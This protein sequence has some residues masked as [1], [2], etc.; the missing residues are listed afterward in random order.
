MP[1]DSWTLRDN[2][3]AVKTNYTERI[4]QEDSCDEWLN[5]ELKQKELGKYQPMP[6]SEADSLLDHSLQAHQHRLRSVVSSNNDFGVPGKHGKFL[7]PAFLSKRW[8]N[9]RRTKLRLQH[10][11][12]VNHSF[13][14]IKK[15]NSNETNYQTKKLHIKLQFHYPI[16]K[17]SKFCK[18]PKQ[19]G[20]L[21]K[22][23]LLQIKIFLLSGFCY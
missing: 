20:L 17:I 15:Q 8:K 16:P 9:P 18:D 13:F 11:D 12:A 4:S 7:I 2:L 23:P 14:F 5:N 21:K 19:V 10:L 1:C 3:L 22:P 6:T